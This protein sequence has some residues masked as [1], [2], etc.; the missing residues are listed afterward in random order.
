MKPQNILAILLITVTTAIVAVSGNIVAT[1]ITDDIR[2]QSVLWI[3]IPLFVIFSAIIT[4]WQFLGS[5]K[6]KLEEPEINS[7]QKQTIQILNYRKISW[8]FVL[9]WMWTPWLVAMILSCISTIFTSRFKNVSSMLLSNYG[10]FVVIILLVGSLART[11][12]L[13]SYNIN[14]KW[15]IYLCLGLYFLL[16]GIYIVTPTILGSLIVIVISIPWA[17]FEMFILPFI[18]KSSNSYSKR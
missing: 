17:V 9:E 12:I 4:G 18:I 10:Y 2:L 16:A 1:L 3:S 6:K 11:L 5:E 7:E 8:G 15:Y 13:I 14:Y